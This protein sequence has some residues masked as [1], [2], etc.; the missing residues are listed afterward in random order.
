MD[1]ARGAGVER[2]GI[3]SEKMIEDAGG[4]VGSVRGRAIPSAVRSGV[5][6]GRLSPEE[7]AS[8]PRAPARGSGGPGRPRRGAPQCPWAR[9]LQPRCKGAATRLAASVPWVGRPLRRRR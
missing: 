5:N 3:I 8:E 9:A 7:A 2:I 4:A 6:L 1:I